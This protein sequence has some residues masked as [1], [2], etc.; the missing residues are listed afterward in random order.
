MG[1]VVDVWMW[2]IFCAVGW[3]KDCVVKLIS[4]LPLSLLWSLS[5]IAN[6]FCCPNFAGSALVVDGRWLITAGMDLSCLVDCFKVKY[7]WW[8]YLQWNK[9]SQL[10]YIQ[11]ANL[12]CLFSGVSTRFFYHGARMK[13]ICRR[14]EAA[15][16]VSDLFQRDSNCYDSCGSNLL[17][18]S[19]D[20][21]TG[22]WFPLCLSCD[23]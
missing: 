3:E 6:N 23:G 17:W 1:P 16:D 5:T 7:F 11:F 18:E 8:A 15:Y 9:G 14:P 12:F 21:Q 10:L 20:V 22:K 13:G 4:S 19:L 2:Y